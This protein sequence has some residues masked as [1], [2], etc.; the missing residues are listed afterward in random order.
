[1]HDLAG[2]QLGRPAYHLLGGA[3][4]D[5]LSPYATVYAARRRARPRRADGRH[6]AAAWR[7]AVE[8]GF[9]AVKMEVLF[10]DRASDRELVAC[11]REGRRVVGDDVELLVDFGYRWRDWRDALW[12]LRRLEGERLFLAEATLPHDDLAS[13]ARLAARVETRVG[14]AELAS[15][16]EECRAWLDVGRVDVLQPDVARAG[17][18]TELRRICQSAAGARRRRGAALL[19]TGINAAAARQ[20]QAASAEVPLIE[21]LVPEL[22]TAP[23]RDGLVAP[24]PPVVDGRIELPRPRALAWS[25]SATS[26]HATPS[27]DAGRA[28]QPNDGPAA[29]GD[30]RGHVDA[31]H[32]AD[33]LAERHRERLGLVRRRHQHRRRR[34]LAGPVHR[35]A[36]A[37]HGAPVQERGRG[38]ARRRASGPPA[39]ARPGRPTARPTAAPGRPPSPGP[40]PGSP[41]C[42]RRRRRRW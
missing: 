41:S 14:G 7:R 33:G 1:M 9:R 35:L 13:H 36:L 37:G 18:L 8:L 38:L 23:L 42:G 29:R 16:W 22:W 2:R 10:E 12:V 6:D 39:P 11:I 5:H 20:L 32:L 21:T 17:G 15:T 28:A 19:E 24:E 34:R 26:S 25:C 30:E 40:G 3:R 31:A 4:R 27:A